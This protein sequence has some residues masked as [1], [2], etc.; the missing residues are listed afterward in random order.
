MHHAICDGCEKVRISCNEGSSYLLTACQF[1]TGVRHKCLDCPDWDYCVDCI[2][3]SEATHPNHR[4]VPIYEAPK[5]N[6]KAFCPASQP[7]H[8]GICC[9]GP[10]CSTG[11][12]YPAYIHGARYK[13]AVC[14]DVDFCASCEASPS[15]THNKSHPLIKFHTPVRH[16]S[17]TTHGEHSDGQQMPVMGDL[18]TPQQSASP[19]S[20]K[21][22]QTVFDTKPQAPIVPTKVKDEN[23]KVKPTPEVV[24]KVDDGNDLRAVFLRDEVRDGTIM[25][26]NQEFE[27]TWVL[28]NEGKATWP[29]GCSVKFVGG[30]YMGHVDS[31]R[32][33]RT[34]EL[35]EASESNVCYAPVAPGQEFSFTVK[36][37]TPP[38]PGKVVSYWR[39]TT[40][41]GFKFGDRLWCE[42]NV[43]VVS[44]KTSAPAVKASPEPKKE[45]EKQEPEIR[46][47]QM[48][49]PKL[50][51]ESPVASVHEEIKTGS[52]QQEEKSAAGDD[53][54]DCGKDDEWDGSDDDFLTDEE[55]DIL[56]ASDEEFLEEQ[57]KKLTK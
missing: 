27:Q 33:A 13:C 8:V 26:P 29:A 11:K 52:S 25:A 57:Q 7:I 12:G 17:V 3:N 41:D 49:F 51:K 28:R 22:P 6:L 38:R 34:A 23:E 16:V 37:R 10:L 36:L 45:Q 42:V 30:D 53:F 21:T 24:V 15:N 31:S 50:E 1:I 46:S 48:I 54:E 39:P 47:S 14:H 18:P 43:R 44:P 5:I 32:P 56:D 2:P 9:D 35:V 55:Y 40:P 20:I 19:L 4:F